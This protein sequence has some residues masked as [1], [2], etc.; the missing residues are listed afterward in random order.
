[1]PGKV[2]P[3]FA[4]QCPIKPLTDC[5]LELRFDSKEANIFHIEQVLHMSLGELPTFISLQAFT[6]APRGKYFSKGPHNLLPVLC[7]MG[8]AQ[9]NLL[10]KSMTVNMYL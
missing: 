6:L 5:R 10:N 8:T 3:H 9:A 7:L 1:M 4:F 2:P